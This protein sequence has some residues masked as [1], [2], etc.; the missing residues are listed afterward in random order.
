MFLEKIGEKVNKTREP[1]LVTIAILDN[2]VVFNILAF[3][4]LTYNP[5]GISTIPALNNRVRENKYP[6]YPFCPLL[7]VVCLNP[8]T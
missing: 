2:L 5:Q 7:I 8:S 4:N 3:L 6:G 1:V